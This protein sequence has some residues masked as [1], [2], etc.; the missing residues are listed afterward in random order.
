MFGRCA[1]MIIMPLIMEPYTSVWITI[2][3]LAAR[4]A[5]VSPNRRVMPLTTGNSV[6][7][8]ALAAG[9]MSDSTRFTPNMLQ[10]TPPASFTLALRNM[11]SAMRRSMPA[12]CMMA[13]KMNAARHSAATG[14]VKPLAAC[15]NLPTPPEST[16]NIGIMMPVMPTGMAWPR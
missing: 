12:A 6:A 3:F 5:G 13:A 10:M 11:A 2:A 16:S 14:V 4:S 7:A 9:M 1:V 8:R 15:G